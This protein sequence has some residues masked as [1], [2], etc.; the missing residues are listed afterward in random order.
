MLLPL[1]LPLFPQLLS[2]RLLVQS[3]GRPLPRRTY[4]SKA[5]QRSPRP[6]QGSEAGE[7]R[8]QRGLD[9]AK[10]RGRK[11]YYSK[12]ATMSNL[13][14]NIRKASLPL[15][16]SSAQ[17]GRLLLQLGYA[18]D[19]QLDAETLAEL[20]KQAS[21]AACQALEA[22][23]KAEAAGAG[24]GEAEAGDAPEG[25]SSEPAAATAE[26][27][28]ADAA[29]AGG[30]EEEGG[31]EDDAKER[32]AREESSAATTGQLSADSSSHPEDLG[33]NN[34]SSQHHNHSLHPESSHQAAETGGDAAAAAGG[35]PSSSL[36]HALSS[37]HSTGS[38]PRGGPAGAPAASPSSRHGAP[39]GAP[40]PVPR[41]RSARSSR[42]PSLH[43]P[44]GIVAAAKE[45]PPS[46]VAVEE[47]AAEAPRK[48]SSDGP[49]TVV[50]SGFDTE[51]DDKIVVCES[52][53]LAH[54]FTRIRNRDTPPQ[55]FRFYASRMMRILAEEV[56]AICMSVL[57]LLFKRLPGD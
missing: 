32:G 22:A 17:L 38:S 40:S 52:R 2:L 8:E 7:E 11:S 56:R 35:A 21:V 20:D 53:A 25:E 6:G 41:F 55:A 27:A 31:G 5:S 57:D 48:S 51:G 14:T 44:G 15:Q 16:E 13:I 43:L 37:V 46:V 49:V 24:M 34:S 39:A 30:A 50:F 10:K 54:L 4:F 47:V 12:K 1:P 28:A 19:S 45:S 33:S 3:L 23:A 18:A 42:E 26:A 36:M 29:D 9:G